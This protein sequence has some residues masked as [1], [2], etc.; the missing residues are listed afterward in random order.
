MVD[1]IMVAFRSLMAFC[2]IMVA[3]T[4]F[5]STILAVL[6]SCTCPQQRHLR[7]VL[8]RAYASAAL[9]VRCTTLQRA[10]LPMIVTTIHRSA[11]GCLR[12]LQ[13]FGP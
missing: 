12:W 1:F 13:L 5:Y 9:A 10:R 11:P 6:P 8:S 4:A 2:F 7:C 3:L